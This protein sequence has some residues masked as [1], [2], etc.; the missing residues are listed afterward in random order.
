MLILCLIVSVAFIGIALAS[1]PG[2]TVEYAGGDVGKV[3]F[4][5]S[6]H[7]VAQGMKCPDCHPKLFPMKRGVYKMTKEDHASENGCGACHNGTAAFSQTDEA[8]CMKCHKKAEEE[9]ITDEAPCEE[10]V[11]VEEDVEIEVEIEEVETEEK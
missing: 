2:K 5:G 6:T 11:T 4:D 1:P 7:S 10:E 8:D 3:I 9:E